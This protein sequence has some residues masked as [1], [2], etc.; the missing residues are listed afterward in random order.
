LP[1]LRR[2]ADFLLAAMLFASLCALSWRRWAS[3]TGDLNR[4]WTTPARVASGE[5]LYRDVSFYY[6]PLA[7]EAEALAMRVLGARVGTVIAFD[8]FTAAGTLALL[9]F[10][11][12]AFLQLLPRAALACF[13][14]GVLAFAPE[15][16][17][18]VAC[19]SQSALIAV[20]LSWLAFLLARRGA[21]AGAGAAGGLALLSKLESAPALLGAFLVLPKR[22]I[23]FLAVGGAVAAA[24]YALALHGLSRE[25]LVHY[26]PLRHVAMPPEFRELYLRVSGL[27][28]AMVRGAALRAGAGA[29]LAFG[30]LLLVAGALAR[31]T[32]RAA[33]ALALLGAGLVARAFAPA[34]PLLTTLTRGIPLLAFAAFVAA[35]L[36]LRRTPLAD[37]DRL[38]ARAALGA[39]VLGLGF[40]WRTV[41]W[42]VPSFP[43]APLAAVSS[44]PAICWLA[45]V[46]AERGVP[47][48]RVGFARLIAF[49][50]LLVSPLVALPRFVAFYRA[51]RTL[52]SAPRGDWYPP[53]D[54]GEVFSR[55]VAHLTRA[56]ATD[57]SFFVLPEASVLNFLLGARSPLRLEQG[58][59]GHLDDVADADAARRVEEIRP[60]RVV[61]VDR[62]TTE[63]SGERFGREY[64]R[65]LAAVVGRDYREEARFASGELRAA[66]L[67]RKDAPPSPVP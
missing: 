19:Y 30:W 33:L 1:F 63:L 42:T 4:E 58:I 15:N 13:A 32:R 22:W 8:I 10:A 26:G 12:R 52:V 46:L 64:G 6:G 62:R 50:P 40:L 17:A 31:S 27:H 51:P 38:A 44:L 61:W 36:E 53:G 35:G 29:A 18:F 24:G 7:P 2:N 45:M 9:I 59:P 39:A 11:S 3:F 34:E 60:A 41:L 23:R 25:E 14:V 56:G 16:G 37:S 67:V 21:G 54:E 43:Y 66:V 55:L 65:R 20:G 28:P 47:P 5:R 49:T 57:R 48:G